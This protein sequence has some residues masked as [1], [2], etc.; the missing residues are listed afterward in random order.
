MDH[1]NTW[2]FA[3][4]THGLQVWNVSNPGSPVFQATAG[5]SSFLSFATDP[6]EGNPVR[7]LDAPPGNDN[8]VAVAVVGG[9]GINVFNTTAKNSPS[10]RYADSNKT[11]SQVWAGRIGGRDYAFAATL[12][13]GANGYDLTTAAGLTN[14][15][16]DD[17]PTSATCGPFKGRFGNRSGYRYIDGTSDATNANAWVAISSGRIARGLEIWNVS[18]PSSPQLVV[19]AF[20]GITDFVHGPAMWKAGSSYFLALRLESGLPTS[21]L[22]IYNVTTCLTGASCSS[23]GSPV[24]TQI[25]PNETDEYYLT[26]S[27]S[28]GRHFLYAGNNNRCS[29]NTQNEWLY[30][31]TNPASPEDIIPSSNYVSWYY[32][33]SPDG[34]NETMPRMG[35][36]V[37]RYF[38]RMMYSLF[39]L[40][41]LTSGGPPTADFTFAPSPA[42]AGQQIDFTSTSLGNPNTH[43][44][45][46]QDGTPPTSTQQNP[47]NVVFASPGTKTV[48]LQ[49]GN[50]FG[51]DSDSQAVQIL[52]PDPAVASVT[53]SPN[54]AFICQPI[55]FTANNVTGFPAP[56]LAWDIQ[57]VDLVTVTTGGNVNPFIWTTT[58]STAP[59]TYTAVVTATNTEGSANQ[60][61]PTLTLNALPNLPAAGT[62]TPTN[63]AFS[64][65]QVQFHI[66]VAGATEWNWDFGDG[67]STGW[68]NDPIAGPNPSH[69]YTD[70]GT[71]NVTVQIRNCQQAARTSALLV[72]NI[73]QV[74]QLEAAFEANCPF[75]VC[76]FSTNQAITFA[77]ASGGDP[78][79]WE[80]AWNNTSES[81]TSCTF[82]QTSSTP[83]TTHSYTSAGTYYPCLRVKRGSTT[84]PLFVHV[85]PILVTSGSSGNPSITISGPTSGTMDQAL[86]FGAIAANCTPSA[87][88]WTWT[89]GGGSGT[90]TS[91]S[92]S[93]TW[94]ST[95]GKSITASNSACSG[96]SDSHSVNI[97][98]TQGGGGTLTANFTFT[99]TSPAPGQSVSFNASSSTGTPTGYSW[100]FGDGATGGGQTATHSFA[101]SGTFQVKLEIT[102]PQAVG[103]NCPFGICT[104]TITKP[105]AVIGTPAAVASFTTNATC[106]ALL[107]SALTGQEVSFTSTSQNAV[108]HE[109]NFGD[110]TTASGTT[111]NHI[112]SQAGAYTVILTVR[113]SESTPAQTSKLF[114]ITVPP[115]RDR[116]LVLPWVSDTSGAI[117]QNSDLYVFNPTSVPM[118][119]TLTFYLRGTPESNP[120]RVSRT[121]PAKATLYVPDVLNTLFSRNETGGFLVLVAN[122]V[123]EPPMMVSLNRTFQTGGLTYGQLVPGLT[124]E[125]LVELGSAGGSTQYLLG[126]FDTSEKLTQIGVTNPHPQAARYRLRFLDRLGNI[127]ATSDQDLTVA[128]FGQKQFQVQEL[129]DR[130]DIQGSE[131]YRVE[132]IQTAG[133]T[134]FAYAG[135]VRTGT[136][137]PSFVEVSQPS[138]RKS[139]LVGATST[140][141]FNNALFVTDV[142]LSNPTTEVMQLDLK[143]RPVGITTTDL[144]PVPLALLPNE[145]QRIADVIFD[146]FGLTDSVGVLTFES[147]GTAGRF[148]MIHGEVYQN[149]GPESRYGLFMPA[150]EPGELAGAG[151]K[152]LLT[153]LRQLEND[154]NTTLLLYNDAATAANCDLIYYNV[155]GA[156]IGRTTGY[157]LSPGGIR[158]INPSRHPI[159]A[160]GVTDGF[161]VVIEVRSG[162]VMAGAQVVINRTNDPAYISA[163]VQ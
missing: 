140:P 12:D 55:T 100:T 142:V 30:D 89:T 4:I 39:D 25:L 23:L 149:G 84:S 80:Y 87:S 37:D 57:N 147:D 53:V 28:A 5:S 52:D 76:A 111:A 125:R 156:E 115:T 124:T 102:R 159:P 60:T 134:L 10:A 157:T 3:G 40:H 31:V 18:N 92:I 58:G 63:D 114:E 141:G 15:C 54:P 103:E 127:I 75:G 131:D 42:Y 29:P 35:K 74:A 136:D 17:T 2:V 161:S 65:G 22:L 135:V 78:T 137:D 90:S 45:T 47:Q 148:P 70:V 48:T 153:G 158:Q 101:T 160:A 1:E 14:A 108:S 163:V 50:Q 126:L 107:C 99:P 19:T 38:Y 139:F 7:D 105:V 133:N 62:F 117:E 43:S 82:T 16:I 64:A 73:T 41:E 132:V 66:S 33:R 69:S 11:A 145:T 85:Q 95:G 21:Q 6:H 79:A 154:S 144:G 86:T 152:L 67:N 143:F 138:L 110:G 83:V 146:R 8:I 71:Y 119:I 72:V 81:A 94:S 36:F 106:T 49:V 155:A 68:L 150:R 24:S 56:T 104:A 118:D 129:R 122:N 27:E 130:F 9:G 162:S 51:T 20:S 44:W 59:G 120:P 61:S 116:T 112:W 98:A 151:E 93:I 123:G 13:A 88:G 121:I 97:S 96:A 32:R 113:N 46:F 109:W 26:H 77:D 128:P 91:N 34:F